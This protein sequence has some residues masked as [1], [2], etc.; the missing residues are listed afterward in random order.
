M[1]QPPEPP[2]TDFGSISKLVPL[3]KQGDRD[4][5]EQ[6]CEQVNGFVTE[7]AEARLDQALRSRVNPSDIAQLSLTRMVDGLGDFRGKTSEEFYAWL[8]TIVKNEV[9]RT[10]RDLQR[11]KRDLRRE[12][13]LGD[14][15]AAEAG[16]IPDRVK[17]PGSIVASVENLRRFQQVIGRL[18]Q[19]DA[20]VIRLRSLQEL[21]FNEVA[22]RMERSTD[23]VTKLW[24]RAIVR[25][26]QE[27][28][29]L[30]ESI[31]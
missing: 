16:A 6:I 11:D 1:N 19:D 31:L 18:S 9:H 25:L 22:E 10:R 21:P 12:T 30:D 7:V 28:E 15:D 20:T 26:Q 5:R 14:R 17:T 27:L 23:A 4:A 13:S 29:R 3:V 2:A 8:R 24:Y